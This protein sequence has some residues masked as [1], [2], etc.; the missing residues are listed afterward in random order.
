MSISPHRLRV[1]ML[2]CP[3]TPRLRDIIGVGLLL[4]YSLQHQTA[5]VMWSS[6]KAIEGH[7][8]EFLEEI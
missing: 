1:G 8:L 6:G 7:T 4:E 2:V 3:R 5:T